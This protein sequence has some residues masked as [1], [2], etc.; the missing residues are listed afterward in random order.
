VW[1]W[2]ADAEF[3]RVGPHDLWVNR[4]AVS[5]DG[6]RAVT[7]GEDR[8]AR[9]WN[10]RTG[11]SVPLIGHNRAIGSVDF[12][13]DGRLVVSG[14]E[15]GSVRV[16]D[17]RTG[18][19]LAELRGH[20]GSVEAEFAAVERI[21]TQGGDDE[22][23]RVW[24][25]NLR[26][27]PVAADA[28]VFGLSDVGVLDAAFSADGRQIVTAGGDQRAVLWDAATGERKRAITVATPSSYDGAQDT[29]ALFSPDGRTLLLS[30]ADGP[31]RIVDL[32][33]GGSRVKRY[34]SSSSEIGAWWFPPVFDPT[35]RFVVTARARSEP[36]RLLDARTG[37]RLGSLPG[38]SGIQ[39]PAFSADGR[40]LVAIDSPE[41]GA[42]ETVSVLAV[43]SLR[44]E[45]ELR[46]PPGRAVLDGASLSSDGRVAA[47]FG[48]DRAELWDVA[49]Q[50]R[51]VVLTGHDGGVN[52]ATFSPGDRFVVTA[53]T[54]GTARV[55]ETSNGHPVAVLSG[56]SDDVAT[57]AFSPDGRR[58][59]TGSLDGSALIQE[60]PACRSADELAAIAGDM[61]SAP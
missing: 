46:P 58:V 49:A 32:A 53:G 9:V 28:A 26:N 51:R 23:G 22:T 21:V 20:A 54:D 18:R 35:G 34:G 52:A 41:E 56:H 31:T 42:D 7:A 5:P 37:R 24:N 14:S 27:L 44:I 55:W 39:A 29:A 19:T 3:V 59:V 33:G 30:T 40:H 45:A 1:I 4:V 47:I 48:L 16:W 17:P 50:R 25:L 36:A 57:V 10:L 6:R 12:S 8:I 38:T 11:R 2:T 60:C 43:P 15:D 13:P 61:S